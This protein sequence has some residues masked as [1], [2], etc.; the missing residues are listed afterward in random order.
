MKQRIWTEMMTY[1]QLVL[2][3]LRLATDLANDRI[4]HR[5]YIILSWFALPHFRILQPIRCLATSKM[6]QH[7]DAN[8][9][10]AASGTRDSAEL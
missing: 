1:C 3:G 10:P 9:A 5:N 8:S 4:V 6:K 2:L 7:S